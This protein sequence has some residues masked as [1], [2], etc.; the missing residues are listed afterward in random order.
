[1]ESL[2]KIVLQS[3]TLKED[4]QLLAKRVI[5]ERVFGSWQ[6]VFLVYFWVLE[7][8]YVGHIWDKFL[9][10]WSSFGVTVPFLSL[11][12]VLNWPWEELRMALFGLKGGLVQKNVP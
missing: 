3:E 2:S 6:A 8:S 12:A 7:S 10:S 1:M 5:L 11:V 4:G 9:V